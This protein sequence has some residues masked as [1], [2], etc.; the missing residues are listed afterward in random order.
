M[1]E[2]PHEAGQLRL[3]IGKADVLLSWCPLWD[4][5]TTVARTARWYRAYEAGE[6]AG[7]LIAEDIEAYENA[8]RS[9]GAS[10]V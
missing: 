10:W 9:A 7:A 4:F 3:D 6:S 8:A 1:G 5:E 2:Q